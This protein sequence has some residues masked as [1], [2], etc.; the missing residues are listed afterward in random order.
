MSARQLRQTAVSGP[1]IVAVRPPII[2]GPYDKNFLPRAMD[3]LRGHRFLLIDGG[4]APLN[5]VWV[6]HLVDVILLAAAHPGAAGHAF[7]VMDEVDT[8]AL[9]SDMVLRLATGMP[10]GVSCAGEREVVKPIAPWPCTS[11]I[12]S[13]V[14]W[15]TWSVRVRTRRGVN[16]LE[17]TRRWR[18]CSGS[19]IDTIESG[20]R[21]IGRTPCAALK[22]SA[23]RD[24]SI[25]SAWRVIA[26]IPERSSN[27]GP[28][29]RSQA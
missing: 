8:D 17:R 12:T 9:F 21:L 20:T 29:S 25:T 15:R 10:S 13:L 28:C 1:I 22:C 16:P 27:H 2:Y 7:N 14:I 23:S 24:A 26:H 18:A 4:E 6:D 3:A 5:V 11:S 19:S